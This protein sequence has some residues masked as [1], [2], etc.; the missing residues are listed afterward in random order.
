MESISVFI[1]SG[2]N[3]YPVKPCGFFCFTGTEGQL[4]GLN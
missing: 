1:P 3:F 2:W 4:D